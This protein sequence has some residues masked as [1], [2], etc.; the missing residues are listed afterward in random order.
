M[1]ETTQKTEENTQKQENKGIRYDK[2][3]DVIGTKES[4]Y[5]NELAVDVL[6]ITDIDNVTPIILE[7]EGEIKENLK[8]KIKEITELTVNFVENG[9]ELSEPM[10]KGW[11]EFLFDGG[12]V[13]KLGENKE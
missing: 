11:I 4:V 3:V 10:K 8:D 5:I 13:E 1:E 6:G 9:V 2:I 7:K 12:I